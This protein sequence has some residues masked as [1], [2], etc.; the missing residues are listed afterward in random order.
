MSASVSIDEMVRTLRGV[1]NQKVW[2]RAEIIRR[3]EVLEAAIALLK[4]LP[5]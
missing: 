2:T 3:E 4:S 5:Q 1:I